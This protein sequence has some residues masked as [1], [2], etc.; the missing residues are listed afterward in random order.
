M[1]PVSSWRSVGASANGFLHEGFLDELIVAAGATQSYPMDGGVESSSSSAIRFRAFS[2][3][4]SGCTDDGW[5][6]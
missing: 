3:A 2:P 4:S 5:P 1:V 6:G